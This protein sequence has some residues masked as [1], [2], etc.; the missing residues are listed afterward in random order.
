MELTIVDESLAT[1]GALIQSF[2]SEV[3]A[4]GVI[5]EPSMMTPG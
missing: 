5:I 2:C 4:A 3:V 1:K